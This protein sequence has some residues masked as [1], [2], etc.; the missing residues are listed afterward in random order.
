MNLSVSEQSHPLNLSVSEQRVR[1]RE[2]WICPCLW[3]IACGSGTHLCVRISTFQQAMQCVSPQ[4]FDLMCFMHVAFLGQG[5][6]L[7]GLVVSG[8][9]SGRPGAP[10]VRVSPRPL[11]ANI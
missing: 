1:S 2:R 3:P 11:R 9:A 6:R 8:L 4:Y 10:T 7:R 5:E